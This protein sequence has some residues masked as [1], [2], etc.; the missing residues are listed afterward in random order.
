M[1]NYLMMWL[2]IL[3]VLGFFA[4]GMDKQRARRQ[5][6]RIPERTLI[7]I[8]FLGGSPGILLGMHLF[9]HKTKHRAFTFGIPA[10]LL[11]QAAVILSR[12]I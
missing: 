5:Q 4:M 11:V 2:C 3:N 9:R 6:W 1:N 7:G 10:I 12:I 8:A